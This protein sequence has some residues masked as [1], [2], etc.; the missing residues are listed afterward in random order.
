MDSSC[1]IEYFQ[2]VTNV[3]FNNEEWFKSILFKKLESHQNYHYEEEHRSIMEKFKFILTNAIFDQ[4]NIFEIMQIYN[5]M[6]F[7]LTHFELRSS[8]Y[9]FLV[10]H[11]PPNDGSKDTWITVKFYNFEGVIMICDNDPEKFTFKIK[12]AKSGTLRIDGEC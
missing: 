11:L 5:S 7:I 8:D 12:N 4:N 10:E 6:P 1:Q 2:T 9:Y 3:V